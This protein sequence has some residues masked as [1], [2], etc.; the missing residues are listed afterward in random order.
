MSTQQTTDDC[1]LITTRSNLHAG[2]GDKS[3]GLID[4]LVQRDP[5]T[6]LPTIYSSS[7]KGALRELTTYH[8][9][10]KIEAIFGSDNRKGKEANLKQ[11]TYTFYDAQLLALPVRA[12]KDF[13]YLATT[14]ELLK[15]FLNTC[16]AALDSKLADA[17]EIL[18]G[19][20]INK[21]KPEY[22]DL[23]DNKLIEDKPDILL[24]DWEAEAYLFDPDLVSLSEILGNRIALFNANDFAQL[25]D[26]LPT[27]ARNALNNGIS[28]QLWY[29][30]VVP[31]E[32]R[33]YTKVRRPN[34]DLHDVITKAGEEVQ[35][36]ANATVGYGVT[37]WK[38]LN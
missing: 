38:R 8:A 36:G 10:G 14:P 12:S 20:T 21:G 7:L 31:R 15:E 18:A 28:E 30:E 34:D 22:L 17:A 29:E 27:L 5:T 11:G 26:D 24:E 23:D 16:R 4:K 9:P 2:A 6:R 3:F 13:Y 32:T 37:H 25:A 35:V 19:K 33:F 1:Y